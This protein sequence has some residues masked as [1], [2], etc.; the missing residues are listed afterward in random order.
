MLLI[1]PL[2]RQSSR[3]PRTTQRTAPKTDKQKNPELETARECY[4]KAANYLAIKKYRG[5]RCRERVL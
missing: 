5:Q 2:R 1:P 4:L 3:T